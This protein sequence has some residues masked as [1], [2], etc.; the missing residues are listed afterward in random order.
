MSSRPNTDSRQCDPA[1]PAPPV[2][3]TG[4]GVPA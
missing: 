2:A 4:T 3:S 1:V